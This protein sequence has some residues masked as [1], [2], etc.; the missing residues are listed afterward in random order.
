MK[1]LL[2]SAALGLSSVSAFAQLPVST[3]V[4][5]KNVV[6]EEFTGIYCTFCPDGHLRAANLKAANPGDVVLINVHTGGFANPGPG[7]PDYRT[8]FGAALE[9]QSNLT[10]YPAGTINR[11]VFAGNSQNPT[12]GT[13][14]SR[15][16]WATT[17]ATVLAE[18]SYVNVALEADV[19][20]RT[21]VMTIDVEMYFTGTAPAQFNLNVAL[22]Q[23]NIAGPQTG[24]AANPS[25]VLPDGRYNHQHMLRN[26]FTGQWGEVIVT[27]G[28]GTTITKQYIYNVPANINGI[29]VNIADLEVAAFIVEGQQNVVTGAN[30]PV[31]YTVPAGLTLVDCG[32]SDKSILPT[33]LCDNKFTPQVE[34]IN[35]STTAVDS[36]EVTYKLNGQA[37]VSKWFT[38]NLAANGKTT[39]TFPQATLVAGNNEVEYNVSFNNVGKLADITTANN[40]LN[41]ETISVLPATVNPVFDGEGFENL[42]NGQPITKGISKDQTGRLFAVTKAIANLPNP[43]GGW[44]SSETALRFDFAGMPAG[45]VVSYVTEKF[46]FSAATAAEIEFD[47]AYALR[48]STLGDEFAVYY[49]ID[50]G[51]NWVQV[52]MKGS[53]DL[54][55]APA[56]AANT[57]FY[58]Q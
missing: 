27:T 10:G 25:Q 5:N 44:G 53:A 4:E 1:K 13:A 17:G 51:A 41:I 24:A 9:G 23:D 48:G 29:P 19:N 47:Y 8:P 18:Q 40:S 39:V 30:G 58:P 7:D 2:F 12:G 45:P 15:G 22:L 43:I 52:W 42:A 46:D 38:G 14:Q 20:L 3:S 55:T 34:L 26:F 50:C 31:T 36:A 16:S 21:N 6:L 32:V 49:S 54:A 33:S 37:A 11:R 35:N 28:A 57:R 56:T